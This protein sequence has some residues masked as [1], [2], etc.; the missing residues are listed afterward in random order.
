MNCK[1]CQYG[2]KVEYMYICV[3]DMVNLIAG[4]KI[5][6]NSLSVR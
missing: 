4:N 3:L 1:I 5:S 2:I 6:S